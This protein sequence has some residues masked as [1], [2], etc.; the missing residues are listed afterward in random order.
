[1]GQ[2]HLHIAPVDVDQGETSVALLL[3]WDVD[4]GVL[5]LTSGASSYTAKMVGS[6]RNLKKSVAADQELSAWLQCKEVQRPL[7]PG[8]LA[9][10]QLRWSVKVIALASSEP[11][12]W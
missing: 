3:L 2:R 6:T 11:C 9:V 8:T 10:H 5:Y 7:V 12:G 1:M 4:H